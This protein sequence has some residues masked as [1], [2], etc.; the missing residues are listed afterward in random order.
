MLFYKFQGTVAVKT[1]CLFLKINIFS[2]IYG[3]LF[4]T[5]FSTITEHDI[6]RFSAGV[7]A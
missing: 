1:F 6:L 7:R 5:I 4:S 2:A 3:D